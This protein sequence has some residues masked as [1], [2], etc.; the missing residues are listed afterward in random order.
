L[1]KALA[2]DAGQAQLMKPGD[3]THWPRPHSRS[4]RPRQHVCSP[5][6][7]PARPQVVPGL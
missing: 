3:Y 4:P 2:S 1:S 7:R 6:L 5:D